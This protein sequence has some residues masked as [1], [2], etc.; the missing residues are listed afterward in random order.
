LSPLFGTRC[1]QSNSAQNSEEDP[2]QLVPNA[3]ELVLQ[4]KRQA[5]DGGELLQL[6]GRQICINLID[7]KW[8]GKK[9]EPKTNVKKLLKIP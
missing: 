5:G 9:I 2:I 6:G 3:D 7:K 8:M 4:I 1:S